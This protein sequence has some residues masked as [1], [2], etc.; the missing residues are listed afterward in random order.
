ML[1]SLEGE[2]IENFNPEPALEVWEN[3]GVTSRR[4]YF[5]N[6]G[7]QKVEV[8]FIVLYVRVMIMIYGKLM[9]SSHI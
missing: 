8:D 1:T 9:Y 4:P 3:S 6:K 7:R 5:N 2:E